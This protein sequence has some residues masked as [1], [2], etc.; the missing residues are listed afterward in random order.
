MCDGPVKKTHDHKPTIVL[1]DSPMQKPSR[2]WVQPW[3]NPHQEMQVTAVAEPAGQ[4]QE[5]HKARKT[6]E[7]AWP[8]PAAVAASSTPVTTALVQA[9]AAA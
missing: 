6:A 3:A 9:A 2:L 5:I 7:T 8:T 4:P 1:Q